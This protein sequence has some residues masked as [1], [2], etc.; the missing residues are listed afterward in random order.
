MRKQTW[1]ACMVCVLAVLPGFVVGGLAAI[2]YRAM[3][4]SEFGSEP[5]FYFMR[6]L[7][8]FEAPG[9]ILEWVLFSAFPT[10]VRGAAAGGIAVILTY[11]AYK[12]TRQ[13]LAIF[14]TGGLY[15]GVAAMGEFLS[16]AMHG[17][18]VALINIPIE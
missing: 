18:T 2:F 8:G 9:K 16:F 7:F 11:Y 17:P 12:G 14:V 1:F 4:A 10:F 3:M 13:D 6:A 15:T 5:D